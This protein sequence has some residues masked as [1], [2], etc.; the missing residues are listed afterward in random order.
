M[1]MG[2]DTLK[3]HCEL[4]AVISSQTAVTVLRSTVH[5]MSM[6]YSTIPRKYN[7]PVVVAQAKE[8]SKSYVHSLHLSS[9]NSH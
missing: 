5:C 6:Q 8:S 7:I 1:Q 3:S 4:C 2:L 9:L